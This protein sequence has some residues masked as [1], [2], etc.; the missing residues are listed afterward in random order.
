MFSSDPKVCK[1]VP[2]EF[3]PVTR[4]HRMDRMDGLIGVV[5]EDVVDGARFV[6]VRVQRILDLFHKA[7]KVC[8]LWYQ[9]LMS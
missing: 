7:G 1:Q 5:A 9:R 8:A 2:T 6:H 4:T 3:H